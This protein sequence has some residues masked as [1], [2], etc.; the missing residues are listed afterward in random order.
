M[1]GLEQHVR[2]PIEPLLAGHGLTMLTLKVNWLTLLPGRSSSYSPLTAALIHDTFESLM[3][4][5]N[6]PASFGGQ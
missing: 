1:C 6:S 3:L 2:C 4:H 5:N